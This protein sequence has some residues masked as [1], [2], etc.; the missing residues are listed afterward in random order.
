MKTRTI[1]LIAVGTFALLFLVH[2]VIAILDVLAAVADAMG[3]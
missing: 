2:G 3:S 1:V